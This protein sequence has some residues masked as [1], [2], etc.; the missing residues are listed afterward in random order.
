[1]LKRSKI[2]KLGKEQNLAGGLQQYETE[3][4]T[5]PMKTRILQSHSGVK[6]KAQLTGRWPSS[7]SD[8]STTKHRADR[9]ITNFLKS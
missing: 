5:A 2:S 3:A 1:M 9:L 6:M 7:L 8:S 4:T